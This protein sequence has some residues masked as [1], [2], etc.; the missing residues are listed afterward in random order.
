MEKFKC[1]N[2]GEEKEINAFPKAPTK[3]GHKLKCHS[4]WNAYMREYYKNK[5][6]KYEKHKLDVR[7]N[8]E[9]YKK[10]YVRHGLTTEE[11]NSM[12][13][14]FDG[15]CHACKKR[16]AAFIDHDHKCCPFQFSCGKCVRGIL[17]SQCNSA[18]G[19]AA[20]DISRLQGLINYLL[21][22]SKG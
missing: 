13:L 16:A 15:K 12:M 5:P 8:D 2:C 3:R 21:D 6:D 9:I 1:K 14:K 20:D 11:F 18:L 4:C 7:K 10:S 17:C 22:Q 19:F